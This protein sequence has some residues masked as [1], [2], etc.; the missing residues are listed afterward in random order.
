[1]G[2]L[3]A[4]SSLSA[5]KRVVPEPGCEWLFHRKPDDDYSRRMAS[6]EMVPT[7]PESQKREVEKPGIRDVVLVVA[8]SSS[9][10]EH[11]QQRNVELVSRAVEH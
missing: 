9:A 4:A 5:A 3:K 11:A 1:M 10:R 2:S 7:A 8:A 6:F